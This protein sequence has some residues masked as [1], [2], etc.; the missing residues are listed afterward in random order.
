MKAPAISRL[1]R[2]PRIAG[3]LRVLVVIAGAAL[4]VLTGAWRRYRSGVGEPSVH[5]GDRWHEGHLILDRNGAT[6]R[7]L[8]SE[9][10]QRGQSLPLE[11]LGDRIIAATL[12]S[13]DRD[14][15][16]HE[17]IDRRAIL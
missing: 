14:F 4:L 10:G 11:A 1:P 7:E 5:L 9:A 17:G 16:G 8:P 12:V 3:R 13:E 2:L 6:L 15:W